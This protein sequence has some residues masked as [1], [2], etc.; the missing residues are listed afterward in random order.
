MGDWLFRVVICTS[1]LLFGN[2]LLDA[3]SRPARKDA[4]NQNLLRQ[5]FIAYIF[6]SKS[7]RSKR[8]RKRNPVP[9]LGEL[10][11]A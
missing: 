6:R 4:T 1:M 5:S 7:V 8:E 3:F 9:F 2:V 10:Y 11:F